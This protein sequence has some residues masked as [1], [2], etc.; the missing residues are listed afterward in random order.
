M[1]ETQSVVKKWYVVRVQTNREDHVKKVLEARVKA[2]GLES[3]II[4]ALVPSEKI[5]EIKGGKKKIRERK[6]FPGYMMVEMILDDETW[7]VIR[8][9]PGIG[10]FLGVNK[11]VPM[12]E[13]EIAGL[14]QD[15]ETSFE[16][17]PKLKISF[18]KGDNVR[19]KEGPFENF[20][21]TVEEVVP[22]KGIVKLIVTIFGRPTP[23]ELEYWQIEQI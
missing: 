15:S 21:G 18:K 14:L 6:V 10:E 20:D 13:H 12:A 19:I 22:S 16:N 23:V 17:K 8:E 3:K 1:G 5:S 4:R 11:P 2:K 9:T 7:F